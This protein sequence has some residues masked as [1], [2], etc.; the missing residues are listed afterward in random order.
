MAFIPGPSYNTSA[1]ASQ[2]D[3]LKDWGNYLS[4]HRDQ[5]QAD[6]IQ[7]WKFQLQQQAA[8]RAEEA[9][10]QSIIN[11][12][13]LEEERRQAISDAQHK[14][15]LLEDQE[16]K[17]LSSEERWALERKSRGMAPLRPTFT[18]TV[19]SGPSDVD[20]HL[21][22][23]AGGPMWGSGMAPNSLP[24]TEEEQGLAQQKL[25]EG[26]RRYIALNLATLDARLSA[27]KE[28]ARKA[29]LHGNKQILHKIEEE[30]KRTQLEY[31]KL[32]RAQAE[33]EAKRERKQRSV[34]DEFRLEA[35]GGASPIEDEIFGNLDFGVEQLEGLDIASDR[36]RTILQRLASMPTSIGGINSGTYNAYLAESDKAREQ[37]RRLKAGVK[38]KEQLEQEFRQQL[39]GRKISDLGSATGRPGTPPGMDY[40]DVPRERV[41]PYGSERRQEFLNRG[42]EQG[43]ITSA[44]AKSLSKMGVADVATGRMPWIKAT[45]EAD[46]RKVFNDRS[47][48]AKLFKD[49]FE[50]SEEVSEK[51]SRVMRDI[52]LKAAQQIWEN[53]EIELPSGYSPLDVFYDI[54]ET[55]DLYSKASATGGSLGKWDEDYVP[56][57]TIKTIIDGWKK[58]HN[59]ERPQS[60][61]T[62]DP[63][64]EAVVSEAVKA[65]NQAPDNMPLFVVK[66]NKGEPEEYSRVQLQKS[67]AKHATFDNRIAGMSDEQYIEF[68]N[69]EHGANIGL[70]ETYYNWVKA[71]LKHFINFTGPAMM[72]GASMYMPGGER[73]HKMLNE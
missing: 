67:K 32:Q 27:L 47:T 57:G 62:S 34:A 64:P 5:T 63:P 33:D 41:Y 2:F 71:K 61:V 50:S 19:G 29:E 21:A 15:K 16:A 72:P 58:L 6:K 18:G 9:H 66:N 14:R 70:T 40:R 17:F 55:R 65:L 68:L 52:A 51:E 54:L 30:Y 4:K 53:P 7:A 73:M 36:Y 69:T 43:I 42:E 13:L 25:A 11:A 39:S 56:H 35:F 48:L 31:A 46:Q 60:G 44:E 38:T 24:P 10:K 22:A 1:A 59:K 37:K 28:E 45:K 8:Q 12:K 23:A 3:Y 26:T 20:P 49:Q